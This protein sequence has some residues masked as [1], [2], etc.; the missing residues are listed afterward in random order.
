LFALEE[1]SADNMFDLI[2]VNNTF[3]GNLPKN[4]DWVDTGSELVEEYPIYGSDL[5]DTMHPWRH[6]SQK[7]ASAILDL[8]QERTGPLVE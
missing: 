3:S 5:V 8:Y 2:V 1:H 4:V 6:D 7:L